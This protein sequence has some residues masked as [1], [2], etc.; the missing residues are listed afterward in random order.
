MT[1]RFLDACALINLYG[2][3]Q[4]TD[5]ARRQP[6]L[7]VPTVVAEAGWVYTRE[8]Q[9]RGPRRAIDLSLLLTEGL[10]EVVEPPPQAVR[11]FLQLVTLLDDGEAMTIACAEARPEAVVVTDDEAA[12]RYLQTLPAPG[13]VTSLTL[14]RDHLESLPLQDRRDTLLNVRIC[15][16]YIPGPR[17]PEFA[18]WSE[19]LS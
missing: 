11:R 17:H 10:I 4:L 19:T 5:L 8:G 2:S 6:F 1:E 13:V 12:V 15:A 14:L 3:G 18:W 7:V 9:E 16:R